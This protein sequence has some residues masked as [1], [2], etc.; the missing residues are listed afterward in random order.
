MTLH[1]SFSHIPT[2]NSL[3]AIQNFQSLHNLTTA[4]GKIDSIFG[5]GLSEYKIDKY[6][7]EAPEAEGGRLEDGRTES[8]V[9]H[10]DPQTADESWKEFLAR[11]G[12]AKEGW[13]VEKQYGTD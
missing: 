2:P 9:I 5:R 10:Y 1:L 12:G 4:I 8:I 13:S 3:G 7:V 11:L 6:G